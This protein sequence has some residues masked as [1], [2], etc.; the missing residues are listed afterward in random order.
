MSENNI[1]KLDKR[2][3]KDLSKTEMEI[4]EFL[5]GCQAKNEI[6]SFAEIINY[7]NTEKGRN[8]KKQTLSTYMLKLTEKNMIKGTRKGR[9][10]MY[11]AIITPTRYE[12][13]KAKSIIDRIY[14]GSIKKF[15]T[16]LYDG[17]DI[18]EEDINEL[19]KWLEDK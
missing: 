15:M 17:G 12:N 2:I 1:T 10:I 5:W 8:W 19:K 18:P 6:L 11:E 3:F 4:M 7:F 9:T 16:A 14:N 13:T